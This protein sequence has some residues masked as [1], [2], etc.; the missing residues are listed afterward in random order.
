VRE[1][2]LLLLEPGGI[3]A[4]PGDPLAAVELEDPSGDIVEE[5]PSKIKRFW[6][7]SLTY[8]S[9]DTIRYCF[10]LKKRSSLILS[11]KDLNIW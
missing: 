6:C 9:S 8:S 3:V 10:L 5:V 1:P 4:F 11:I 7:V 2:V